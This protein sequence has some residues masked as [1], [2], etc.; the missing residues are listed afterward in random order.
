MKPF[1]SVRFFCS[2][3]FI[4][5][6]QSSLAATTDSVNVVG[7]D[8]GV[9]TDTP[10]ASVHVVRAN[11]DKP[12]LLLESEGGLVPTAWEIKSNPNTGRLT[13]KD[14]NGSTTPFK[15]Q[16]SA[17]ENLLRIG[18][19]NDST[20]DING[21][22]IVTG[23][24]TEQDGACADYVFEDDYQLRPLVEVQEFIN[25]NGHLPNI[26]SADDMQANGVNIAHISG[27][28]LEKIEELTLYTLQQEESIQELK[29]LIHSQSEIIKAQKDRMNEIELKI[30]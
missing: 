25:E 13:F 9:G 24:C 11:G 22:L 30:E 4:F 28:L 17:Q 2:I 14:L 23:N 12:S 19:V 3:A 10:A 27:R 7:G 18:I 6:A 1:T 15:F 29:Q 20:V 16:H 21:H 5:S 8:F 26:P